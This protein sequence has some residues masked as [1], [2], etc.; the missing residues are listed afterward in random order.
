M[1]Q[2]LY[3]KLIQECIIELVDYTGTCIDDKKF[4]NICDK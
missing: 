3:N 4:L 2:D 1:N